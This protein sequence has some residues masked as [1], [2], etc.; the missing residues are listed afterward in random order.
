M[1]LRRDFRLSLLA[2]AFHRRRLAV[3]FPNSLLSSSQSL[4]VCLHYTA[5]LS[6]LS[7]HSFR[8]TR[9]L[10]F[11]Q[12]GAPKPQ[13]RFGR[14]AWAGFRKHGRAAG[15]RGQRDK[16]HG[17]FLAAEYPEPGNFLEIPPVFHIHKR[18]NAMSEANFALLWM[19]KT[20]GFRGNCPRSG[21]CR[22]KH[23]V[24][25]APLSPPVC[26][27]SLRSR[28]LPPN[29]MALAPGLPTGGKRRQRE[30]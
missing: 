22:Q 25:F 23:P 30:R 24:P 19:W 29:G 16:G 8:V 28:W 4:S 21:Y 17:V 10:I 3:A 27:L 7:R 18:T 1:Q 15:R 12:Q 20:A 11:G 14:R 2:P 6:R 13:C 9:K 5:V 26:S